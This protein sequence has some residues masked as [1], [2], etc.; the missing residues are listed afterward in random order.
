MSEKD[1]RS[2]TPVNMPK[3]EGGSGSHATVATAKRPMKDLEITS[4]KVVGTGS[5]ALVLVGYCYTYCGYEVRT[6][7]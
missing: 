5:E 2:R 7:Y 4:E 1:V 3:T 6:T